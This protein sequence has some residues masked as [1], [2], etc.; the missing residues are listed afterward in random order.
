M[1]GR[2]S[3]LT[4]VLPGIRTVGLHSGE[5]GPICDGSG[6]ASRGWLRALFESPYSS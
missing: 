4:P 5:P 3:S 1:G 2:D 6:P